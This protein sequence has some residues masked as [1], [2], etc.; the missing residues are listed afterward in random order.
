MRIDEIKTYFKEEYMNEICFS[1]LGNVNNVSAVD[2]K[3]KS[4]PKVGL[5]SKPDEF[6]KTN[7]QDSSNDGKFTLKEALKNFGK[8]LISPITVA[9][10]HP[11]A[12]LATLAGVGVACMAVPVLTPI[13]TVGFGA[14]SLYQLGK[15]T[16]NTIKDYSNGNYDNAEKALRELQKEL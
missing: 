4:S 13:L 2:A 10:K 6:V 14:L 8:G 15:S 5:E 9:I 3:M 1:G 11:F 12:T 7:K 16:V